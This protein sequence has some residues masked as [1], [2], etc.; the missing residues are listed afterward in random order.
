ME[1]FP[2]RLHS[3]GDKAWCVVGNGLSNQTFIDAPEGIIAID[4]G[5][6]VEEMTA[7]IALLRTATSRPIAAVMYTHFH[8]VNG[9]TAAFADAGST[10]PVWGHSRIATNRTRT[11]S[12]IAPTY[13]RGLVEQFGTSLPLDGP[14]G[15]VGVGLGTYFR[16]PAHAPHTPGYVEADHTFDSACRITVAG[17]EMDIT[18][19]PSDADDS[20]TISIP[21]LDLVVNNL[22]WPV[23]FNVFAIRG[24]EYRDP[25][26]LLAGLDQLLSVRANHLIGAHGIPI[27]GRDEITKRVGRYR[28]S[29]Q[30]L[31]DQTV[32]HTNRGATS[33]DLAHLVRLPEWAD[34]DYLTTEHYG[35]AEH[36]TRQI[37][38]GL[39]GF[40]DGNEANLFPYPTVERNDRYIA[41]LGGRDTV[42]ASCTRAL[43]ANDVR[44][45]LELASMLATSTNAEDDDRKALAHVLRTIATRTTSANIRNWCLTRAR[46][47]DGSADG[48]RLTTHRFSRGALLAGSADNAV[49]V[50]RVLVD[51][52]AIDGV[53]A[54]VAFDFAEH[55]TSGLHVRNNVCVPTNGDGAQHVVSCSMATWAGLL[56]GS[57]TLTAA[58]A[59]KDVV[60]RGDE[61][62]VTRVLRAFDP[63][64][65]RS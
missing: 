64:G 62:L 39:F 54:H 58:L 1:M 2:P 65:F 52:S 17:L 53:D 3:V 36:H 24:E 44:W 35:V 5:E 34:D 41:A 38:S 28:D 13:T 50:L 21:S 20:V 40:F 43:E 33:A 55:G 6:C 4:T 10:L 63:Q 31:W 48:S 9:T 23:L 37:R 61:A 56:T 51:P 15:I 22:V 32:R 7:A 60:I 42:R 27:S 57:T 11:A 8:Y 45:A 18:P 46:Q 12:A 26:I 47:W 16:N 29:I 19:A 30:F 25:M 49:H 14:D 59:S